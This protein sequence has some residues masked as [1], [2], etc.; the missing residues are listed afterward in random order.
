MRNSIRKLLAWLLILGLLLPQALGLG[1]LS[2]AAA[3]EVSSPAVEWPEE[4]ETDPTERINLALNKT[5]TASLESAGYP[6]SLAVD[7][8]ESTRWYDGDISISEGNWLQVDLGAIY[9]LDEIEVFWATITD[10]Q[11]YEIQVSDD[12]TNWK[13]IFTV[14]SQ[15]MFEGEL[16][17]NF[18]VYGVGRYVRIYV[19]ER[20]AWGNSVCE[21]KVYGDQEEHL[22]S[23]HIDAEDAELLSGSNGAPKKVDV[24]EACGGQVVDGFYV[25]VNTAN[26]GAGVKFSPENLSAEKR[27]YLLYVGYARYFYEKADTIGVYVNDVRVNRLDLRA[28]SDNVNRTIRSAPVEVEL[29][30]GDIIA[31]KVDAASG[32]HGYLRLDYI[33]L[34][35]KINR[36]SRDMT[37]VYPKLALDVDET[38]RILVE[39]KQGSALEF[40]AEDETIAAF[41]GDVLTAKAEGVTRIMARDK[42]NPVVYAIGQV[43]VGGAVLEGAV[44]PVRELTLKEETLTVANRQSVQAEATTNEGAGTHLL[45]ES[46]DPTVATVADGKIT[47]MS[48][49]TATITV[50]SALNEELSDSLNVTVTDSANVDT[51]KSDELEVLVSKSFPMVYQYK[52]LSN[53]GVVQ[54]NPNQS[55]QIK[56]NG[57]RYTPQVA[58]KRWTTPPPSTPS[59]SRS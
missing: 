35:I 53:G 12:G 51:L 59:K 38:A 9:G 26:D 11:K 40:F 17:H 45:W 37:L 39:Y 41:E 42:N 49:G 3:P 16:R 8:N 25:D 21:L 56:L 33:D 15:R 14:D 1:T 52:T 29:Q 54:G 46:S 22:Y 10:A 4:G 47:G 48:A 23:S 20:G 44:T 13:H 30:K 2:V 58:Y 57:E 50:K 18:Q 55:A 32:D 43:A 19:L 31:L 6:A 5:A 27:T 34:G 24:K 7:G 28:E 36:P